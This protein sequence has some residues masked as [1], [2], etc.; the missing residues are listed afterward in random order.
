MP[1]EMTFPMYTSSTCST[2][3]PALSTA[4]LMQILPVEWLALDHNMDKAIWTWILQYF[5]VSRE[6]LHNTFSTVQVPKNRLFS[7]SY[8]RTK[9]KINY[10]VERKVELK[11]TTRQ[12]KLSN[13][14]SLVAGTSFI[15][16]MKLP[17]GVRAALAMTTSCRTK[18][19]QWYHDRYNI[20]WLIVT[21][22]P[23]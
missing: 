11:N 14:P 20:M 17:K 1:A 8:R 13:Q 7:L 16:P 6:Q 19:L 15:A 3:I 12:F 2:L 21:Q 10:K 4:E 22:I 5:T 23:I 18:G 9:V